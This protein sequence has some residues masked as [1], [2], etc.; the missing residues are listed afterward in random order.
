MEVETQASNRSSVEKECEEEAA[1]NQATREVNFGDL[2][3]V[4]LHGSTW[5]PAQVFDENTVSGS[6][7]PGNRSVGE[8]LVRLYGSYKYLYVDPHGSR[9]EFENILKESNGSY[10]EILKNSLD[11]EFSRFKS[12][13]SKGTKSKSRE[14]TMARSSKQKQE[15]LQKKPKTDQ[16]ICVRMSQ[17]RPSAASTSQPSVKNGNLVS[18][19]A[20]GAKNNKRK[21]DGGQKKLEPNGPSYVSAWFPLKF[22]H[23]SCGPVHCVTMEP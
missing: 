23:E 4:R 16:T 21:Q 19:K 13:G 5:W 17:R 7:R 2:I 6:T 1:V 18:E 9:L 3:W 20:E 12:R 8:V 14:N 11:L 15:G 10:R 22:V